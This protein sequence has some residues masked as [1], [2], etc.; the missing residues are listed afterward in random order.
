VSVRLRLSI[1]RAPPPR[2]SG[3]SGGVLIDRMEQTEKSPLANPERE[4]APVTDT[5]SSSSDSDDTDSETGSSDGDSTGVEYDSDWTSTDE[6]I[7]E[8]EFAEVPA[9]VLTQRRPGASSQAAQASPV[10][11]SETCAGQPKRRVKRKRTMYEKYFLETIAFVLL[12][13]GTLSYYATQYFHGGFNGGAVDTEAG[14]SE[15]QRIR[16]W[17]WPDESE[18]HHIRHRWNHVVTTLWTPDDDE[19]SFQLN[20][21]DEHDLSPEGG[22]HLPM[23]EFFFQHNIYGISAHH[24]ADDSLAV[25]AEA[26]NRIAHKELRVDLEKLDPKPDYILD[27]VVEGRADGREE[28]GFAVCYRNTRPQAELKKGER[29]VL[30]QARIYGQ[31]GMHKWFVHQYGEHPRNHAVIIQSIEPTGAAMY[32]I[33]TSGPVNRV[34]WVDPSKQKPYQVEGQ[35]QHTPKEEQYPRRRPKRNVPGDENAIGDGN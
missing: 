11:L 13:I 12:T 9:S 10:E 32:R 3:D 26:Y 35:G 16:Y 30:V 15:K 18:H 5:S 31:L 34:R 14:L 23:P 7:P 24:P 2:E 8:S 21:G 20:V 27:L 33:R 6:D 4:E 17:D 29:A 19:V 22:G 1:L 25:N 28:E